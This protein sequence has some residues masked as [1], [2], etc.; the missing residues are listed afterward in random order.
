V[1][2]RWHLPAFASEGEQLIA[3]RLNLVC[4]VHHYR[5]QVCHFLAQ[6]RR[7]PVVNLA[8]VAS[9]AKLSGEGG[10]QRPQRLQVSLELEG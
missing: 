9:F 4:G 10:L 6:V 8:A 2:A 7:A 3:Q 1:A 5:A